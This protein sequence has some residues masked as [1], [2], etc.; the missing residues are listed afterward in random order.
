ML[1]KEMRVRQTEQGLIATDVPQAKPKEAKNV[2]PTVTINDTQ[3]VELVN[4][5]CVGSILDV[6]E[7]TARDEIVMTFLLFSELK[8]SR[9]HVSKRQTDAE[10]QLL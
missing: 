7:P 2:R 1:L 6:V 4:A 10:S 8:A 9:L 5:R 3:A